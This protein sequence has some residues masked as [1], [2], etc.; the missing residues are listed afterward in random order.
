MEQPCS[1]TLV[2][3]KKKVVKLRSKETGKLLAS[4]FGLSEGQLILKRC[5]EPLITGARVILIRMKGGDK[6]RVLKSFSY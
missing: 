1:S 3:R 6:I 2:R 4:E 5:Q